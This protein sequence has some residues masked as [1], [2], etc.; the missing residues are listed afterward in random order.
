MIFKQIGPGFCDN[1]GV[2]VYSF[3]GL[4]I[5]DAHSNDDQV[6]GDKTMKPEQKFMPEASKH[7]VKY[8]NEIP[9]IIQIFS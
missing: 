4:E 3:P 5:G 6:Q 1:L 7:E 2:Q 8:S 9:R